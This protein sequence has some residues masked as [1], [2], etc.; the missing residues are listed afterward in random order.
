MNNSSII[1]QI[2]SEMK[3]MMSELN[4][5]IVTELR[6]PISELE[7]SLRAPI[8]MMADDISTIKVVLDKLQKN[9]R[10]LEDIIDVSESINDKVS[11]LENISKL[12]DIAEEMKSAVQPVI[13]L[14]GDIEDFHVFHRK[15]EESQNSLNEKTDDILSN[16]TKVLDFLNTKV[17]EFHNSTT[18]TLSSKL[19]TLETALAELSASY[20][21][22]MDTLSS[23]LNCSLTSLTETETDGLKSTLAKV[24]K[25]EEETKKAISASFRSCIDELQLAFNTNTKRVDTVEKLISEIKSLI[26]ENRQIFENIHHELRSNMDERFARLENKLNEIAQGQHKYSNNAESRF[27]FIKEILEKILYISTPFW[28]RKKLNKE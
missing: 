28:N 3:A 8:N 11:E 9:V 18:L 10:V 21:K 7:G 16:S 23:D 22:S 2:D 15:N 19:S 4:S 1:V 6:S 5:D 14:K 17:E 24:S 27:A 25:C 26:G 20:I 13:G 12:S